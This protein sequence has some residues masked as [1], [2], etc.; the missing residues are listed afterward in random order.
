VLREVNLPAGSTFAVSNPVSEAALAAELASR[1]AGTS[2]DAS[3]L[4]NVNPTTVI[5][6]EHG[7]EVLVHLDSVQVRL[8]TGSLLVSVDLE[9]DQTGRSTLV[10]AFAFGGASDPAG[11]TAVTDDLPK[12]L[13]TLTARWG[14]TLQAAIWASLLGFVQDA[15]AQQGGAPIGIAVSQGS[16]T[17]IAGTLLTAQPRS[18]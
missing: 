10:A 9:T 13:G 7:D 3:Q 18:V 6:I 16:L 5:W 8:L 4:V 14:K 17:V 12:G 1:L 15:A 2:G 11:L